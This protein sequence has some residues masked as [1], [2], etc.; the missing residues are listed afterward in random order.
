MN[1]ILPAI[2]VG[3]LSAVATA[4]PAGAG[5]A[6]FETWRLDRLEA[7]DEAT[8]DRLHFEYSRAWEEAW[9]GARRG[10]RVSNGCGTHEHW[11]NTTEVELEH[12]V[13]SGVSVEF[14]YRDASRLSH[15]ETLTAIG[16]SYRRPNGSFVRARYRPSYHKADHDLE[17]SAGWRDDDVSLVRLTL[18]FE[19]FLNNRIARKG[20]L[21]SESRWIYER[22]PLVAELDVRFRFS[23]T[24]M[25]DVNAAALGRTDRSHLAPEARGV[26][27]ADF[28]QSLE[29]DRGRVRV[30]FPSWGRVAFS[31]HTGWKRLDDDRRRDPETS[32]VRSAV[33][34]SEWWMRASA[35]VS[36][37]PRW[38][39]ELLVEYRD[40]EETRTADRRYRYESLS[41]LYQA[42]VFWRPNERFDVGFGYAIDDLSGIASDDPTWLVARRHPP[43]R[44]ESRLH[45]TLQLHVR[46]LWVLV[47]ETVELDDEPYSSFAMHDKTFVQ[48]M[49]TF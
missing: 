18:A 30:W 44:I 4:P 21:L 19:R 49:T 36:V 11:E 26:T 34:R 8:L 47:R 28:R 14:G 33:D 17:L 22:H 37:R 20:S 41:R 10:F 23:G 25:I 31:V 7:D 42:S 39:T 46:D 16:A 27:D 45:L 9:W 48:V 1:R 2:L 35:E 32:V 40:A 38:R 13:D 24:G 12:V 15:Q 43:D 6:E 29:G 3:C 5:L